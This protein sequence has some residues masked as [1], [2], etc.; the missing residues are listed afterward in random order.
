MTILISGA[1]KAHPSA[2]RFADYVAGLIN[3]QLGLSQTELDTLHRDLPKADFT[4][5]RFPGHAYGSFLLT[6]VDGVLRVI[7]ERDLPEWRHEVNVVNLL[8]EFKRGR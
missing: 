1:T 6:K 2:V 5:Y 4:E 3:E 7:D 8:I